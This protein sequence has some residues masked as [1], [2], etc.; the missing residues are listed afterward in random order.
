MRLKPFRQFDENDVINLFSLAEASGDA[1]SLVEL[2]S[3]NPSDS[4]GYDSNAE[5]SP[6]PGITI[7]RYVSKAKV[8]LATAGS[9]DKI[10]GAML[11][12][13]R[14]QDVL[15]RPLIYTMQRYL[16]LQTVTSGQAVPVVT[17]AI[18]TVSGMTGTPA[19]GSGIGVDAG[20]NGNWTVI[21]PAV[22]PSLGKWLSS[23]GA[24]GYAIASLHVK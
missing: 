20:G 16:E 24:D 4:D 15:G 12:D 22:T 19:P 11:W 14:E 3:W 8:K 21:G 17:K 13:V 1:G 18:L 9:E 23:T 6:F 5:L 10:L 7:P 2:V